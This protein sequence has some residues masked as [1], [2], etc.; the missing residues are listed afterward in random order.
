M[1]TRQ[2]FVSNSSSSSFIIGYGIVKNH[3]KLIDYLKNNQI[4]VD[5]CEVS[6]VNKENWNEQIRWYQD[7]DD[8]NYETIL[9]GGNRSVIFFDKNLP[10]E[11]EVLLVEITN[12]E[13]DQ[14]FC[15]YGK[16]LNYSKAFNKNYYSDKQQKIIE[17]LE[18]DN[19]MLEKTVLK[20]GAE[21]N[22]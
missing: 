6:L 1:K 2:G 14:D 8:N 9:I 11:K 7:I 19:D 21:R 22:G 20:F 17:L 16:E 15:N 10:L 18:K 12:N 4:E 13:G 5:D 3:D